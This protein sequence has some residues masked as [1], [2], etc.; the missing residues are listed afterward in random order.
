[1]GVREV[2]GPFYAYFG[3]ALLAFEGIIGH[4]MV[5]RDKSDPAPPS[6]CPSA[7]AI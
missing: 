2:P 4:A 7:V 5:R 6:R 1:M 3:D